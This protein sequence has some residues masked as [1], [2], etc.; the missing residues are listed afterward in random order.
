MVVVLVGDIIGGGELWKFCKSEYVVLKG[1]IDC[2]AGQ[3][4]ALFHPLDCFIVLAEF[5]LVVKGGVIGKES[6]RESRAGVKG[7]H[8][9]FEQ[10]MQLMASIA[11]SD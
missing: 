3:W 10:L 5:C 8:W 4:T 9:G 11:S 2:F 1:L 7:W 6:W